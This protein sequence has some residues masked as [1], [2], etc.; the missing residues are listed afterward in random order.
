MDLKKIIESAQVPN[1]IAS[2]NEAKFSPKKLRKVADL[3][4][5]IMGREIGGGKAALLG[6]SLGYEQFEKPGIGKGEGFKYLMS[7]GK[8]IRFGFLNKA[9]SQYM[10]NQVD[11]WEIG[12]KYDKPSMSVTLADWMNIVDVVKELKAVLNGEKFESFQKTRTLYESAPK[13][14]IAYGASK[15]VDYDGESDYKY[16]KMLKNLGVWD[17]DEYRGFKISTNTAEKNSTTKVLKEADKKLEERKFADPDIIFDDIEDLTKIVGSG[18]QNSMI[19]A[20]MAGVGKTFHVEKSLKE[21]FGSPK[22]PD[23]RWRHRKGAKLSP[24]GLYSDLFINRT[25]MTIV[26]DDSKLL[27]A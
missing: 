22:G 9:K 26:Y 23:A 7:N 1:G 19:I 25:D 11:L 2:L 16:T 24:L 10:I 8:M 13:K 5:T 4:A 14:L 20:G 17:E 15:G 27:A 21:M 6:G 12:A 3:L 18:A